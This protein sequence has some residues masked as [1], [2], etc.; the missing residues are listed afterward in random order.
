MVDEFLKPVTSE[1]VAAADVVVTL[2]CGDAC[3]V[4]P[5]R[6]YVDWDLADLSGLDV[7]S[8]RSVC[9]AL[10]GRVDALARE[11]LGLPVS[12]RLADLDLGRSV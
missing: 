11:L 2:G 4:L 1:V 5:G 6:R 12:G 8:A 9:D 3:A 7:E 10:A